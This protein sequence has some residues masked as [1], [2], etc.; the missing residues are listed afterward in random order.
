MRVH[1]NRAPGGECQRDA[2][3][4]IAAIP[5]DLNDVQDLDYEADASQ[6]ER[7]A[8]KV[9]PVCKPVELA[10]AKIWDDAMANVIRRNQRE[11]KR[12]SAI[13]SA[14]G[15]PKQLSHSR[16]TNFMV[17]GAGIERRSPERYL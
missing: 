17:P 4:L 6:S 1:F 3:E 16:E 10:T 12:M 14:D 9:H 5:A 2:E 7:Y 15:K 13:V 8:A 11:P